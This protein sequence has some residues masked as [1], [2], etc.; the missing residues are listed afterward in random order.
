MAYTEIS[1]V[2]LREGSRYAGVVAEDFV[3]NYPTSSVD[4]WT[5]I[6]YRVFWPERQICELVFAK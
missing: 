1:T 2:W 5:W 6:E 3:N 4:L